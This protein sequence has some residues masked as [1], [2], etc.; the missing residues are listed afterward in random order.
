MA[1]EKEVIQIPIVFLGMEDV[2]ILYVNQFVV[3]H[4]QAEFILTL[5]QVTPPLLQG[6]EEEQ[7]E[8]ARQLSH[9]PVKVV[10]RLGMTRERVEEL[11]IALQTNVEA[12]DKRVRNADG[13][14]QHEL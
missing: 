12:Y 2:P 14:D 3:Q 9:I 8:Q 4:Q 11:I 6:T 7:R 10:A 13:D 1:E 5:G